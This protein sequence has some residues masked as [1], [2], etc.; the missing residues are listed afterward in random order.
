MNW[1][2]PKLHLFL[3]T[4][5]LDTLPMNSNFHLVHFLQ[6]DGYSMASFV[7]DFIII[8]SPLPLFLSYLEHMRRTTSS[9]FSSKSGCEWSKK[10]LSFI[11]VLFSCSNPNHRRALALRQSCLPLFESGI[12]GIR[13]SRKWIIVQISG[14]LSID[15]KWTSFKWISH[16]NKI[17]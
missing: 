5:S 10:L 15:S 9:Q 17:F 12:P 4:C 13:T 8:I 11:L 2:S 14:K 3:H 16:P 7:P 1:S 6:V